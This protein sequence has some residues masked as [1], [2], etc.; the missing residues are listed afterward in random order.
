MIGPVEQV[1]L[2][3]DPLALDRPGEA[4]VQISATFNTTGIS[5]GRVINVVGDYIA[6]DDE[7]G[8][9]DD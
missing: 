8:V 9:H 1:A 4:V 2:R 3:R 5:G 6:G 7:P